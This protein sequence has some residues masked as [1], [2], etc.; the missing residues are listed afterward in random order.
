MK[1]SYTGKEHIA[2]IF[3]RERTDR[4]PVRVFHGLRPG[5]ELASVTAKEVRTEPDKYVLVLAALYEVLPQDAVSILIADEALFAEAAGKRLSFTFVDVRA[6]AAA[7][8]SLLE[9]KSTLAQFELPDLE[10]GERLPYFLEI[11][12]G[13]LCAM[14]DA[15]VDPMFTAPWSTAML[16]RGP[17]NMLL[18]TQDDPPFL[19]ELLSYTTDV[20]KMVGAALLDTG[21]DVLTIADPSAGSSLISP[22]MFKQWVEPYLRETIKYL[23]RQKDIPI[24]LHICGQVDPIMED[25][26][27]LGVDGISIDGPSSLERLVQVSK[28]RVVVEGNCPTGLYLTGTAEEIEAQVRECVDVAAGGNAYILCSGCQV[29]DSA[30]L[31]NVRHF[32]EFGQQYGRYEKA[33]A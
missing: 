21:A 31:E 33:A 24:I 23:K 27:S 25:L 12:Q 8:I 3:R 18:D 1:R 19:H 14:P 30:P 20:A 13:A 4:V 22:T 28:G 15:A 11:C 32:L 26:V 5:L 16:M 9:D 17:Q 7:G 10:Q 2:A 6:R 29:P